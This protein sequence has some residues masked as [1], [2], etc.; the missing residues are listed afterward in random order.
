MTQ[1][2]GP[3]AERYPCTLD[4]GLPEVQPEPV[5][6]DMPV[7]V[8]DARTARL[9]LALGA[10]AG[11]VDGSGVPAVAASALP[12]VIAA[13][14]SVPVLAIGGVRLGEAE[15]GQV[16]QRAEP[17]GALGRTHGEQ[18]IVVDEAGFG[19]MRGELAG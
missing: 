7:R 3:H 11:P 12:C 10:T 4:G 2:V 6:R 18:Q 9:V 13:H 5:P 16:G 14:G 17:G 15:S 19:D 8:D 1:V